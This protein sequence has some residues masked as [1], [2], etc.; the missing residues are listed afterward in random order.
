MST[1]LSMWLGIA[2]VFLAIAATIL[3]AWL[4]SFPMVP[5]PGGPDP[6]G[7]STAPRLGTQSHRITGFLYLTIYVA[8]MCEMVPR[9]WE[10]QVELPARTVVHACMG[11]VIGVLL[12]AKIAIIRWFQHFGKSLPGI[13]LSLLGCTI[14]LATLSVPFAMRAH[15][16]GAVTTPENLSRVRM[17]LAELP[18]EDG[19]KPDLEAL[20]TPDA[21]AVGQR[22]LAGKCTDCHDIRTILQKPRSGDAWYD[23]VVRMAKK[24]TIGEPIDEPEVAAVTAYLVAITPD[25]QASTK[26]KRQ[27]DQAR[28]KVVEEAATEPETPEGPAGADPAKGKELLP[29]KCVDCHELTEVEKHGGETLEGWT[30]VCKRMVSE[31]GAELTDAEI[32]CIAAHLAIVH[33]KGAASP[34]PEN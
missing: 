28:A 23:V 2:F 29:K 14:I 6:N 32:A 27:T 1:T 7:R 8:L 3:Q 16:F 17:I 20:V 10:Y 21:L 5:D 19:Q 22:V 13:G 4:W 30:K 18:W 12:V 9:L 26:L 11:I 34:P 31:Q 33:P 15:D 24:P 25:I